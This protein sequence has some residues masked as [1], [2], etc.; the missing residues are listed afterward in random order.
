MGRGVSEF[1]T[2]AGLAVSVPFGASP[3][4]ERAESLARLKDRTA[5]TKLNAA[6]VLNNCLLFILPFSLS[7]HLPMSRCK[8]PELSWIDRRRN[9]SVNPRRKS[10]RPRAR[11]AASVIRGRDV[12]NTK[13]RATEGGD[14]PEATVGRNLLQFVA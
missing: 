13:K 14:G 12:K 10:T 2:A 1:W 5:A 3:V 8:D 11:E 6:A 4:P 9:A 7:G